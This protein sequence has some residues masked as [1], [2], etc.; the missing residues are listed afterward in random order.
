MFK[1]IL[2]G[3]TCLFASIIFILNPC[4]AGPGS[5]GANFLKLGVGARPVGMGEAF[6]GVADDLNSLYWNPAGLNSIKDKKEVTFMHN[7]W[8]EGIN[9][10]YLAYG[11]RMKDFGVLGGSFSFVGYGNIP[12]TKEDNAG[13]YAGEDGSFTASDISFNISYAEKIMGECDL[14]VGLNIISSKIENY[15][16]FAFYFNI[17]LLYQVKKVKGLSLGFAI[18]NLGTSLKFIEK[19]SPLPLN[20]KFGAGYKVYSDKNNSI[21]TAL[22]VN[23]PIDNKINLNIGGEYWFKDMLAVRIGYKTLIVSEL[24]GLAGLSAGLG[25]K[26]QDYNLDYAF[27][28]YGDLGS[29]HRISISAKF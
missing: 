28:P 2:F 22:D 5:T 4:L 23:V 15:S 27:V 17:G 25:F 7:I 24:G 9:Y 18:Q 16:A 11:Q 12:R 14:G 21:L 3:G 10:S 6:C 19:D 29:T 13:D 8:F 26:W 20:F 1:K